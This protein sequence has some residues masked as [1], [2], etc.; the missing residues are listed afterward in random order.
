MRITG[1]ATTRAH[2]EQAD[3][4]RRPFRRTVTAGL[5]GALLLVGGVG[6][7]L[8]VGNPPYQQDESSHVGYVL[9]LRE[10]DLPSLE[11]PVPTAGGGDLLKLALQRPYP[12]SQRTIHI[13][14]NPPFPYLAA[15][16]FAE[17]TSRLDVPGGPLLGV[18]LLD[19][20]GATVAIGM[21]FLLGRELGGDNDFLGL[22]T[23]GFVAGVMGI[24][25]VSAAANI[26]G[27][28]FAATT[29]VTWALARFARTRSTR[30]A[31]VLGLWCAGAAAVR[32]MSLVFAAV[33]GALALVLAWQAVGA[34][35]I[36]PLAVRLAGPTVVLT[37]WFYVVNVARYGDFT[38]SA[39]VFDQQGI[40]G[41]PGLIDVLW[42]PGPFV[43]T[44]TYLSTEVYG[45]SPWW[46]YSGPRPYLI[47]ALA[48]I[49]LG[50]AI[51]LSMRS[52]RAPGPE[53]PDTS[54]RTTGLVPSAWISVA[55]LVPVPMLLIAQH[56][57]GGG[58]GH[59]RYLFPVV[60]IFAAAFALVLTTINR[61]LTVLAVGLYV[62]AEVTRIRAAGNLTLPG[63]KIFAAPLRESLLGQPYRGLAVGVA[64][65]GA[66]LLMV[67]LIRLA[68]PARH[69]KPRDDSGR[70]MATRGGTAS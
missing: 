70:T 22:T 10:G 23:A 14:N 1:R 9:A 21:A 3:A 45:R 54:E 69:S 40:H 16:P 46:L 6:L 32:P 8:A 67:A 44:L 24:P 28:A 48:V 19:V 30:S 34:R 12:F 43:Q 37:G 53:R 60:P 36:L 41:G 47:A 33:A 2:G 51:A 62:L 59:P 56:I 57:H 20:A 58:A 15:L 18:R 55:V 49:V 26:D 5:I 7:F 50:V 17:I 65:A 31:T 38:G 66:V 13:A 35:R 27:I 11:T 4:M 64:I 42:S 61:W 63:P 29:G 25:I 39:A 52:S 68:L